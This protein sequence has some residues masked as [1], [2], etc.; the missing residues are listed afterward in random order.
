MPCLQ[1]GAVLRLD[2][3]LLHRGEAPRNFGAARFSQRLPVEDK[4]VLRE[5]NDQR[6]AERNREDDLEERGDQV[7]LYNSAPL[8]TNSTDFSCMPFST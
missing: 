4:R 8:R 1:P 6:Q 7:L 2:E 3:D 5:I